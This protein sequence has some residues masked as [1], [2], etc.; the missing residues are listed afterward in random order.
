[1]V[2]EKIETYDDERKNGA[3]SSHDRS[4]DG[5]VEKR[6]FERF[7]ITEKSTVVWFQSS[8][9]TDQRNDTNCNKITS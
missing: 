4:S 3:S 1:M 8:T 9:Y 5:T 7:I 6:V 2:D